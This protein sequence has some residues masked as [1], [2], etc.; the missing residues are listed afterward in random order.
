MLLCC[1]QQAGFQESST[2]C[3]NV[4]SGFPRQLWPAGG[5]PPSSSLVQRELEHSVAQAEFPLSQRRRWKSEEGKERIGLII[6]LINGKLL[7]CEDYEK[8]HVMRKTDRWIEFDLS[9][10]VCKHSPLHPQA[11]RRPQRSKLVA[12]LLGSL[13]THGFFSAQGSLWWL[14][15]FFMC[16]PPLLLC[17]SD[18]SFRI[19]KWL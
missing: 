13:N 2:P 11:T 5:L 18:F 8:E 6:P 12:A 16:P 3:L 9:V 17:I 19:V 1:K 10:P 4:N 14:T 7:V 15:N